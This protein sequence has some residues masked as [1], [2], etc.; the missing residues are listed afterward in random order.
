MF[1]SVKSKTRHAEN[2]ILN[3]AQNSAL[4][5]DPHLRSSPFE[6][7]GKKDAEAG[8]VNRARKKRAL[9]KDPHLRSSPFEG[10]GEKD[11]ENGI[12]NRARKKRALNKDPH[13]RSSP[14]EGE[15]KRHS[16]ARS[17][18]WT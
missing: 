8:I 11:A 7:E 9:N 1:I 12:L 5:Q 18:E 13:L 4:H 15:G 10:E 6:G 17:S 16:S 3:R 2:G 14:S